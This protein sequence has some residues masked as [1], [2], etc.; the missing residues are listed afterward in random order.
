[1]LS[2]EKRK[3]LA[4]ARSKLIKDK[5]I[6]SPEYLKLLLEN[7]DTILEL[8]APGAAEVCKQLNIRDDIV[9]ES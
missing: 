9:I 8:E 4:E 6:E 2:H 3:E 5:G 7:I 1:M